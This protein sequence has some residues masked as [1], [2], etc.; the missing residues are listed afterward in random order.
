MK[1]PL[2]GIRVLDLGRTIAGLFG[3]MLMA[4]LGAEVIKIEG[5]IGDILR[6]HTW[7]TYKNESDAHIACNTDKKDIVLDLS[8]PL[9]K[10]AFLDLVKISDVVHNNF[11]QGVMERLG[12]DYDKLKGIN[13]RIIYSQI[14]GFG[15]TGP[16]S[17]RPCYDPIAEAYSGMLSVTGHPGSPPVRPG[18]AIVDLGTGM[19][20]A[21]GILAAVIHR[22]QTGVGQKVNASLLDTAVQLMTCHIQYYLLSG[23]IP[24]PT[25]SGYLGTGAHG[26]FKTKD[27]YIVIGS[28]WPRITR[29]LGLE[30][31]ADDPRFNTRLGRW[32][33]R[34]DLDP[35]LEE[36]FEEAT[37]EQWI[38]LLEIEDIAHGPVKNVEEAVNDP[39]VLHNE[40]I[41]NVPHPLGGEIKVVGCPIKM[42]T[43]QGKH[44]AAPFNGQHTDKVLRELLGYSEEKV[45]QLKKQQER[46]FAKLET[47]VKKTIP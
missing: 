10:E 37:N 47:H 40:M 43:I 39:Q 35:V 13:P 30:Q 5:P 31:M 12:L 23:E 9:G 36:K 18:P 4:E 22:N 33:N 44:E 19:L 7:P 45:A 32:K 46:N 15:E 38:N 26:A 25:G 41:I 14:T 20:S 29:V 42:P 2:S 16:Y 34:R 21:I 11:R 1:G 3:G 27:G 8:T 6:E 17:N 24:G 28:A